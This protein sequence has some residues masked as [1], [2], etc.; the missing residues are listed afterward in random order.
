MRGI[1]PVVAIIMLLVITVAVVGLGFVFITGFVNTVGGV[2]VQV[3]GVSFCG[4]VEVQGVIVKQILVMVSIQNVG[5][6]TIDIQTQLP[7]DVSIPEVLP[8]LSLAKNNLLNRFPISSWTCF[9][10]VNIAFLP[11]PLEPGE[12]GEILIFDLSFCPPGDT[13][14]FDVIVGGVAYPTLA[15]C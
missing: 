15:Q 10:W 6:Q 7:S 11:C 1:T 13:C 3:P 5:Q 2:L 4:P 14:S 8:G 9:D 12:T